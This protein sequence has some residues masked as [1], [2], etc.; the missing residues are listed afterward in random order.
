MTT[1]KVS[2]TATALVILAVMGMW[3]MEMASAAA[4]AAQCVVE[5]RLLIDACKPIISG[6]PP[7]PQCCG[8]LRVSQFACLCPMITPKLAALIGPSRAVRILE[9]CGRRLPRH[10]KCGS[11]TFP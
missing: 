5:K 3:E 11:I 1:K 2:W 6:R 9:G 4:S 10:F 8:R 7:S